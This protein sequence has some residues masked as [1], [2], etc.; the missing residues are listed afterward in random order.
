MLGTIIGI[1]LVAGY[2]FAICYALNSGRSHQFTTNVPA[3]QLRR[4][5][6][7][8]AGVYGWRIY[9]NGFT[10]IAESTAHVF[11]GRQ[12]LWLV[13]TKNAAG[14]TIVVVQP[15][16]VI[17]RFGVPQR[18]LP[19]RRRIDDFVRSVRALDPAIE[20]TRQ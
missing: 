9:D 14:E 10:M 15:T 3:D 13:L 19:L 7:Q 20:V 5:F 18:P 17:R 12:Q 4:L 8:H 2:F 1:P 6:M 11:Y 16:A